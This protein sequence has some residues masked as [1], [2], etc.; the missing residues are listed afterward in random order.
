MEQGTKKNKKKR[1]A[2]YIGDHL[3]ITKKK[4]KSK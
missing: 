1:K 3:S 2:F 4:K